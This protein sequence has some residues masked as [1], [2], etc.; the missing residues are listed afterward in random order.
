MVDEEKTVPTKAEKTFNKIQHPSM[1]KKK[2]KATQ[3]FRNRR[4]PSQSNEGHLKKSSLA[5]LTK[6][7]K[8]G[9][10]DSKY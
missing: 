2:Y 5:R 7:K 1:M 6:K 9:G 4:R 3:T 10:E 8:R